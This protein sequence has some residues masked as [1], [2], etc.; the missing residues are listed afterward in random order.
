MEEKRV[1][2]TVKSETVHNVILENRKKI[3]VSGV[4]DVESFNEEEIVLHTKEQGIL[5]IKGA[6]LHINRLSIDTGD[7][8]ITGEINA[9]EYLAVSLKSKG[10]GFFGKLFK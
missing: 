8:N 3:S 2:K 5:L 4:D 10:S 6:S 7:V 9:M 1:V